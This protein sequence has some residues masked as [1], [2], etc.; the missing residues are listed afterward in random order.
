MKSERIKVKLG[1][2]GK[3]ALEK[4]GQEHSHYLHNCRVL[5]EGYT[6]GLR[7]CVVDGGFNHYIWE[8]TLV[9]P[10]STLKN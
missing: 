5:Y 10:V 2:L 8:N 1:I 6:T 7:V 9:I 4:V 3:A